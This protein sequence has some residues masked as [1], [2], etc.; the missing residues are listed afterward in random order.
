MTPGYT[1]HCIQ[2]RSILH[3]VHDAARLSELGILVC[4]AVCQHPFIPAVNLGLDCHYN[5]Y[6]HHPLWHRW[7]KLAPSMPTRTLDLRSLDDTGLLEVKNC[8]TY[9]APLGHSCPELKEYTVNRESVKHKQPQEPRHPISK[10]S[11][12]T[13]WGT[14]EWSMA[15]CTLCPDTV[16]NP[17][18]A[19]INMPPY[20]INPKGVF[21]H[22]FLFL[23]FILIYFLLL[24]RLYYIFF[25]SLFFLVSHLA[26]IILGIKCRLS[27]EESRNCKHI[28]MT[29][30]NHTSLT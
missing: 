29:I 20:Q 21:Y 6:F 17:I 9:F 13:S 26:C 7:N 3:L 14:Y 30:S 1:K 28:P 12:T 2:N 18:R 4:L 10:N 24:F 27:M 19:P 11:W 25:F 8:I 22:I 23:L 15:T 5:C 16:D